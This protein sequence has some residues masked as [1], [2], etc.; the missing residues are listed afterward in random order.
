MDRRMFLMAVAGGFAAAG[1]VGIGMAEAA[2]VSAPPSDLAGIRSAL[3]TAPAAGEP[4]EMHRRHG[5]RH[6][7]PPWRPRRWRRRC[8]INR[9]G[10]RV[11]RG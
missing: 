5:R 2:P 8:W 11:C 7:R 1:A 10:F 3:G 9:R 4:A 6:G